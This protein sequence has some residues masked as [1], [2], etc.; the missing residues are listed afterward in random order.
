MTEVKKD[1]YGE[2]KALSFKY[3]NCQICSNSEL[4]MTSNVCQYCI[5]NNKNN[6]YYL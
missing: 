5:K 2:K 4:P 6:E 3:S 1:K